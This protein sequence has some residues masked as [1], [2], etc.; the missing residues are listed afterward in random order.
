[1]SNFSPKN[2]KKDKKKK[3]KK[4]ARSRSRKRKGLATKT[5]STAVESTEGNGAGIRDTASPS[6]SSKGTIKKKAQRKW[7]NIRKAVEV[8]SS[9]E[10][11]RTTTSA[12]QTTFLKRII[13]KKKSV[14]I[15]SKTSPKDIEKKM[16][17]MD[18]EINNLDRDI[19]N[20][21]ADMKKYSNAFYNLGKDFSSIEIDAKD[22]KPKKKWTKGELADKISWLTRSTAQLKSIKK[23]KV[24]EKETELKKIADMNLIGDEAKK[25][26]S[27]IKKIEKAITDIDSIEPDGE[28]E[29]GEKDDKKKPT[30]DELEKEIDELK[31]EK[32][33]LKNKR[34]KKRKKRNKDD[35]KKLKKLK[36]LEAKMG[37]PENWMGKKGVEKHLKA[38][39]EQGAHAFINPENDNNIK[40]TWGGWGLDKNF[41]A[42]QGE[43]NEMMEKA[44]RQDGKGIADL[45]KD[46]GV[47]V[48]DWILKSRTEDGKYIMKRYMINP[49]KIKDAGLD[50]ARGAENQ[51]YDDEWV[52]GGKTLGGNT[53]A[54]VKAFRGDDFKKAL[55]DG[56]ITIAEV[57]M[58]E[59][60]RRGVTA[61]IAHYDKLITDNPNHNSPEVMALRKKK[62]SL[63]IME[64][65]DQIIETENQSRDLN[66]QLTRLEKEKS[67][68]D[69]PPVGV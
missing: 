6:P 17:M 34:K 12:M 37:D 49:N 19:V 48:G 43:A 40:T 42:P 45:E 18:S 51:A 67:E 21:N 46:L 5:K 4:K 36:A 38:I 39:E 60:T 33:R 47:G 26:S 28:G 11:D 2:N 53:E 9:K 35:K 7:G 27:D 8:A 63:Q 30:K 24:E 29:D 57:D 62:N 56:T 31:K 10:D 69:S 1:M 68:L 65:K 15:D 66:E 3:R 23:K 54:T 14:R 50:M 20:M 16:A 64:A 13:G 41:V 55:A 25:V 52:A 22:G 44:I 61:A 32:N 58:T 59:S